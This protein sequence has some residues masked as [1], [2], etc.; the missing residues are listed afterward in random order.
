MAILR[1]MLSN[2]TEHSLVLHWFGC[3]LR[4]TWNVENRDEMKYVL[5][6]DSGIKPWK[7]FKFLV[8]R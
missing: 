8:G 3:A 4:K 2:K 1:K 6:L 7:D 5:E